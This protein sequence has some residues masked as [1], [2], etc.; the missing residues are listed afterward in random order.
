MRGLKF[1]LIILVTAAAV[2]ILW[3]FALPLFKG[4]DAFLKITTPKIEAGVFLDGEK[5]GKTPY[6]GEKM[7]V[8]DYNLKLEGTLPEPF[9][10]QVSFST[11]LTLTSQALTAV[12]YEFGPNEKFSSGDIRT[13]KDGNG[14]SVITHP[15]GANV[16]L[17][18]KLVGKSPT[19]LKPNKG[20]HKLKISADGFITR[21]LEINVEADFKLE[22][23]VYIAQNPF[24]QIN[25][26]EEGTLLVYDLSNKLESLFAESSFWAEGV[27]FFEENVKITFDVL[28]DTS[29]KTYY[30]DEDALEA[31]IKNKNQIIVGYLGNK[32]DNRLTT[33][34]QQTLNELKQQV[35][36][37]KAAVKKQVQILS[38]P[39]GILNVRE[40]PG[41]S[42]D[43]VTKIKPGEKYDLL[44][45]KGD[46]YK[47]ELPNQTGWVSSQYVKK[48]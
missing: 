19:S 43:I 48:L 26:L 27:F 41:T 29:G 40:G 7:Q 24:G 2:I 37:K 34:A 36:V 46:W 42:Y 11:S 33:K 1:L 15:S 47:I 13:F 20:V 6:L 3:K 16:W 38:T 30:K 14:L 17:D 28:I 8:G 12:N 10:K 9:N 23:E 25:K 32:N 39:T 4:S 22:V 5:I 35:G 21:E 18:G 44:E 45:E 31:T